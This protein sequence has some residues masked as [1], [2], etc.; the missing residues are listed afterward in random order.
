VPRSQVASHSCLLGVFVLRRPAIH[1]R[2]RDG[3][4]SRE[5]QAFSCPTVNQTCGAED[6]STAGVD[7]VH[8]QGKLPDIESEKPRYLSL[9]HSLDR[10]RGPVSDF[11]SASDLDGRPAEYRFNE[12]VAKPPFARGNYGSTWSL[13]PA[14]PAQQALKIS[15]P[16][17]S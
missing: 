4:R 7:P 9:P 6:I 15:F 11:R 2:K 14:T 10:E 5:S 12:F 17:L 16:S 13:V 8:A 3:V 1:F